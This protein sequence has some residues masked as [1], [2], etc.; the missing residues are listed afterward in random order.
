M[1]HLASLQHRKV[2]DKKTAEKADE[3]NDSFLCNKHAKSGNVYMLDFL[4]RFEVESLLYQ[5]RYVD[6]IK[7]RKMLLMNQMIF[8]PRANFSLIR[9]LFSPQP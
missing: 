7:S 4:N 1:L 6:S 2:V 9:G 8:G 5:N 3:I